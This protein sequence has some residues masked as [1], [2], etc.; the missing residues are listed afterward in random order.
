MI[1]ANVK[2]FIQL[3]DLVNDQIGQYGQAEIELVGELETL[4]DQLTG[5]EVSVLCSYIN[6]DRIDDMEYEAIE[7]MIE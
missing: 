1:T 4:G 3:Q 2:R 6:E 5:D 7:W